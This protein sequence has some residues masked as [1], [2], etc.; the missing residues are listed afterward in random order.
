M[1]HSSFGMAG[2]GRRLTFSERIYIV[3]TYYQTNSF[4]HIFDNWNNKFET[5]A[6]TKRTCQVL[7]AKFEKTGCVEYAP[8][9]GAPKVVTNDEN[10]RKLQRKASSELQISRRS[11]GRIMT[12]ID[13][14][15]FRP[16]LLQ[17]LNGDDPD[18][19]Q[20]FCEEFLSLYH[21]DSKIVDKVIW[22]DEVTF[23][24]NG[25][26]NRHNSVYW[27]DENPHEILCKEANMPGIT[28]WG[29]LTSN[30]LI[31]TFFF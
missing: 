23:K 5:D 24:L 30:G 31:G 19:R 22:T 16:R 18:R 6:A 8:K 4:K 1:L 25:R 13:L 3:K 12:E 14:K 28:V 10:M 17:A 11:L 26:I 15:P 2:H 29:A 20:Q 27:A 7:I 21:L 9:C